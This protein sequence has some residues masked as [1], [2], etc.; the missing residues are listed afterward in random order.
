MVI[1]NKVGMFGAG[2]LL[3]MLVFSPLASAQGIQSPP[4]GQAARRVI[5]DIALREGGVL[6]GQ[7]LNRQGQPVKQGA[8]KL[9]QN[10]RVVAQ[11]VSDERGNFSVD[12]LR[13]GVYAIQ[14]GEHT[15]YHRLWT[16]DQAPPAANRGLLI[17]DG[18]M[19]ARGQ[20]AG[21]GALGAAAPGRPQSAVTCYSTNSSST[22]T[23]R[24][25]AISTA[26]GAELVGCVKQSRGSGGSAL[27]LERR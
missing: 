6:H 4:Q 7:V 14:S 8:V 12:G 27:A 9:I 19:A 1:G 10:E 5:G 17:V 11:T 3:V 20:I 24:P 21:F 2:A 26:L 16:A 18:P 23:I 22:T 13:S 15:S 25:R